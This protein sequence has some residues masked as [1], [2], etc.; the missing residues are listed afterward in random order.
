MIRRTFGAVLSIPAIL[1]AGCDSVPTLTFA[2]GDASS[3]TMN[4]DM[5]DARDATMQPSSEAGCPDLPPNG[6]SA[7]CHS[8]ACS[9]DCD[10]HCSECEIKCPAAGSVCCARNGVSCHP[11]GFPC[12]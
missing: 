3:D 4:A 2:P 8:V 11:I 9:G 5:P 10:A 12:K 1:L 7:C 6:T